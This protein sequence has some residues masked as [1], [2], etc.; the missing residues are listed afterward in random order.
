MSYSYTVEVPESIVKD[1]LSGSRRADCVVPTG[2]VTGIQL[3]RNE[4]ANDTVKL[5]VYVTEK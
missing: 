2:K 5:F 1:I 3:V 4:Q